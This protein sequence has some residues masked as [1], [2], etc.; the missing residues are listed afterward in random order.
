MNQSLYKEAIPQNIFNNFLIS[1]NIPV[2]DLLP[3][4]RKNY[5]PR[6]YFP[7]DPHWTEMGHKFAAEQI[8]NFLKAYFIKQ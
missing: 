2:L 6:L 4:F 5:S 8:Y 7:L 1:Q 3:L